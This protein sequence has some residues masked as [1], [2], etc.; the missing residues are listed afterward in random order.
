MSNGPKNRGPEIDYEKLVAEMK[1]QGVFSRE[2]ELNLMTR[3]GITFGSVLASSAF[4]AC[5]IPVVGHVA[6][7]VGD[8]NTGRQMGYAVKTKQI[9]AAQAVKM[10]EAKAKRAQ[11]QLEPQPF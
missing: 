2:P 9:H 5:S 3:A 1:L 7:G 10:E 6:R 4:I 8:F 11:L